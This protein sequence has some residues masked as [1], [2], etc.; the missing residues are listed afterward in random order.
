MAYDEMLAERLRAVLPQEGLREQKMF[1]GLAF[2]LDD[3]M[4]CGVVHDALMLRL[5]PDLGAEALRRPYVRPMDFSGRTMR[6]MVFV[7]PPGLVGE[8]LQEWVSQAVAFTRELPPK[9][10]GRGRSRG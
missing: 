1:G 2:M 6:A 8:S 9:A 7:D 4:V 3:H 5:G 10:P